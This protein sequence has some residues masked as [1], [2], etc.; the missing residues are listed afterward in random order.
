MQPVVQRRQHQP[1]MNIDTELV[2]APAST[3]V[4]V[5]PPPRPTFAGQRVTFFMP[6]SGHPDVDELLL[7]IPDGVDRSAMSGDTTSRPIAEPMDGAGE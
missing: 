6:S 5:E 4:T 7:P 2:A 3:G 1:I